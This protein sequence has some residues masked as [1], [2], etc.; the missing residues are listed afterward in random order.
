MGLN[1]SQA[2]VTERDA[3]LYHRR[4]QIET[5]FREIKRVQKMQEPGGLRGRTKEA[6][7]YEVAGHVLLHLLARWLMVEAAVEHSR[8]PLR[9]SFTATLHEVRHTAKLLP[10]C[11]PR[12]QRRLIEQMLLKI[13]AAVVP[14]RPA[15]H[16]P[17]PNDGK[18]RRT[19]AGHRITPAHL[20]RCKA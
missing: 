14:H 12:R 9:L 15:R 8:D 18:V 19:G 16:Y 13:A 6:I 20:K 2:W 3:A 7:E 4:W 10:L 1:E 5:A 11:T 17:R